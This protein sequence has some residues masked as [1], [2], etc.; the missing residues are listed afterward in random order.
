MLWNFT[1]LS[2][3]VNNDYSFG[4]AYVSLDGNE[5]FE[6]FLYYQNN[7]PV[8]PGMNWMGAAF[9]HYG[10]ISSASVRVYCDA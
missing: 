4:H 5:Y 7:I 3:Y 2:T 1:Y 10:S 9:Y 8:L 6:L